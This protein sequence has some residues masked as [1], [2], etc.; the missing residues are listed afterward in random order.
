MIIIIISKQKKNVNIYL[1]NER[2][3][4]VNSEQ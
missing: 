1:H 4:E 2:S 3:K